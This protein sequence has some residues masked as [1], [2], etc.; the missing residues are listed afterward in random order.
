MAASC[1]AKGCLGKYSLSPTAFSE[2]THRNGEAGLWLTRVFKFSRVA[3][4]AGEAIKSTRSL[5][6][7]RMF[8]LRVLKVV[9]PPRYI[10]NLFALSS[11]I[12]VGCSSSMK[13]RSSNHL[14]IISLFSWI[15]E[16]RGSEPLSSSQMKCSSLASSGGGV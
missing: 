11:Q 6:S 8:S 14:R 15:P 13:T 1:S 9:T 4:P 12:G 10:V 3:S 7:L 16:G 2:S 5:M